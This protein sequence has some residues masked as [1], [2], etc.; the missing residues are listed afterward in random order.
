MYLFLR[1]IGR[2]MRA[3]AVVVA[4]SI[5]LALVYGFVRVHERPAAGVTLVFL[6]I[7]LCLA[8]FVWRRSTAA[9]TRPETKLEQQVMK[10]AREMTAQHVP[11]LVNWP[12]GLG[13]SGQ[14]MMS[15]YMPDV[16]IGGIPFEARMIPLS[17]LM[18][19]QFTVFIPAAPTANTTQLAS[20]TGP[21]D[22]PFLKGALPDLAA[23]VRDVFTYHSQLPS[24]QR[25]S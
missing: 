22:F 1:D 17:G 20:S 14:R 7:G 8:E 6:A 25:A 3:Y 21:D 16:A 24:L 4:A 13:R 19:G 23:G 12:G 15:A 10:I 9:K 5:P 18:H 11:A 2:Q